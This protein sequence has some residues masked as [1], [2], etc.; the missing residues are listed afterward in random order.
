MRITSVLHKNIT[1]CLQSELKHGLLDQETSTLTIKDVCACLIFSAHLYCARRS[2]AMSC[3]E[4]TLSSKVNNN[5]AYGHCYNFAEQQLQL[6]VYRLKCTRS[7][8]QTAL[9]SPTCRFKGDGEIDI[10]LTVHPHV[11]YMFL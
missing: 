11:M 7:S 2:H 9:S 10:V 3:I 8:H 6:H 4:R 5:R 1:Q